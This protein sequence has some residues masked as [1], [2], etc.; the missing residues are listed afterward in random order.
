M[1]VLGTTETKE[2]EA[3]Q[4]HDALAMDADGSDGCL[5]RVIKE[6]DVIVL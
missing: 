4:S 6:R 5:V 2:S 3:V 1:A